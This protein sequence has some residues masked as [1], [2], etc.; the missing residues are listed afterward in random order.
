MVKKENK[1]ES[2]RASVDSETDK[3]YFIKNCLVELGFN[4]QST[5]CENI[6]IRRNL[7]WSWDYETK[8]TL[9]ENNSGLYTN[10]NLVSSYY[11]STTILG[12]CLPY[13][14]TGVK[15]IF[16]IAGLPLALKSL[17][18]LGYGIR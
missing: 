6:Y 5:D 7:G 11:G 4:N 18:G 1:T 13:N 14:K 3:N 15:S 8:I 10:F 12:G 2:N 16:E 17:K 9:L